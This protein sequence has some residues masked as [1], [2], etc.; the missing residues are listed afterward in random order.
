[1]VLRVPGREGRHEGVDP[2]D[3]VVGGL[4]EGLLDHIEDGPMTDEADLE[5]KVVLRLPMGVHR[6]RAHPGSLSDLARGGGVKATREEC[7]ER[8]QEEEARGLG[9]D[10]SP[11][12]GVVI[13]RRGPTSPLPLAGRHGGESRRRSVGSKRALAC[14]RCPSAEQARFRQGRPDGAEGREPR[15]GVLDG[16]ARRSAPWRALSLSM[17]G[18]VALGAATHRAPVSARAR[19]GCAHAPRTRGRTPCA[20]AVQ[21]RQSCQLSCHVSHPRSALCPSRP[22][23]SARSG[24]RFR[25]SSSLICAGAS[26]PRAGPPKSSSRIGRRACSWRRCRRSPAT[27][28]PS[29]TGAS[30]RRR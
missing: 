14:L 19:P 15:S 25:R 20:V 1:M 7:V 10:V 16:F 24:L 29:T 18:G 28:R 2:L 17:D 27:G 12:L 21:S 6:G 5:E 26:R 11:Q 23:P 4:L 13:E 30:A 22:Q 8:R 9:F 3:R